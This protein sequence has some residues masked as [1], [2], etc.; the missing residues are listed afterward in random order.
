[1]YH[2]VFYITCLL[3]VWLFG[4]F[5]AD[6][7]ILL[8][9][10][11]PAKPYTDSLNKDKL[12]HITTILRRDTDLYSPFYQILR[13]MSAHKSSQVRFL[14]FQLTHYVFCR[15]A[16]F[17]KVVCNSNLYSF[18]N[19][20]CGFLPPPEQFATRL[21]SILSFVLHQWNERF[22]ERYC[23]LKM[24][25]KLF[26]T[27]E[28]KEQQMEA[29]GIQNISMKMRHIQ[30]T[31]GP[32][33][34]EMTNLIGLLV[35]NLDN[36]AVI[37]P[38]EEYR[39]IVLDAMKSNKTLLEKCIEEVDFLKMMVRKQTCTED[40]IEQISSLSSL[41]SSI[42]AKSVRLGIDE[43]DFEDVVD[44]EEPTHETE[45][46]FEDV[47]PYDVEKGDDD[48]IPSDDFLENEG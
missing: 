21:K 26:H 31:Y 36:F 43:D 5:M 7:D 39:D 29:V 19:N 46:E 18:L 6:L 9:Q 38:T 10:L 27:E 12:K 42:H 34:T 17:R 25:D 41:V 8:K 48:E 30:E 44:D 47:A 35:P 32:M 16:H 28:T 37:N 24:V 2:L 14:C 4:H 1:M 40:I 23:I 22:G 15:S 3:F 13:D 20:F 11:L 33:L 45:D